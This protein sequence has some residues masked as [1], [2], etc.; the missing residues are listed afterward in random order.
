MRRPLIKLLT[1][2]SIVLVLAILAASCKKSP[3]NTNTGYIPPV[4]P[5]VDTTKAVNYTLL[6]S[7]EFNGTSVDTSKWIFET[8]SRYNNEKEYYLAANATVANGNLVIT[9]KNETQG[10]FPFTSA[11][12]NTAN[13]FFVT[14]GKIEARIKLPMGAGLWP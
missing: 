14:Y 4:T 1:G 13:K 6:W 2:T 9:A 8:G 12:M 5:P 3:V 11:R 7:D 10:G